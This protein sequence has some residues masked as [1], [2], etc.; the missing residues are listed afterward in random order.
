MRSWLTRV[1]T[2]SLLIS[3]MSVQAVP[4][5]WWSAGSPPVLSGSPAENKG[6]ASA[7]QGKWM[8]Q[9]ALTAL[10][11]KVGA[12]HPA[13]T[14]IT[15]ELYKASAT[16]EEG[17][18][19]PVRPATPDAAWLEAQKAPL[20]IGALKALA[21][22]FYRHIGKLNEEWIVDQFV[23]NGLLT[24]NVHYFRDNENLPKVYYPWNPANNQNPETNSASVTI[25]QLKAVFSLYFET[26]V[27]TDD[28]DGDGLG[29]ADEVLHGTNPELAD[30]DGDSLP[31][32]WEVEHGLDPLG[33]TNTYGDPDGEGV[34][35]VYEFVLGFDPN[36]ANTAGTS[37]ATKDRDGDGMTDAWEAFWGL[38]QWDEEAG[39]SVITKRI[40]W[41]VADSTA[42]YDGDGLT[43]FQEFTILS[44]PVTKDTD[45]DGMP[46]A[47]ELANNLQVNSSDWSSDPDN[48]DISNLDEYLLGL[49]PRNA[50]TGGTSDKTKDRDGDGILDR[51]EVSYVRVT[52]DENNDKI[53]E[54]TLDWEVADATADY[55]GDGLSNE[56]EFVEGTHPLLND[57]DYDNM[58][59]GWEIDNGFDPMQEA[60]QNIDTDNDGVKNIHEFVLGLDPR[61]ATTT[62]GV[63]DDT[64]DGDSDGMPDAWEAS[65]GR[66]VADP[67]TNHRNFQKTLDWTIDDSEEDFDEDE[68]E[69]LEEFLEGTNPTFFDSDGDQMP[70]GWEARH[71]LD[72]DSSVGSEGPNADPDNDGLDN[73]E[74]WCHGT[75]PHRAN[76]DG[77]GND[78]TNDG[79]EV[80]QGSDPNDS[81]DNGQAPPDLISVPI[82]IGDPSGSFS[83]KWCL[84]VRGLD[85]D[86]RTFSVASREF[87]DV[88]TE[89]ILLRKG[90][91]YEISIIHQG[92][93]PAW[94]A[95]P[96]AQP[97]YDWEATIDGKPEESAYPYQT[98]SG[99]LFTVADHWI[100]DNRLG[101]FTKYGDTGNENKIQGHHA[102]LIPGIRRDED[103]SDDN[104]QFL[105][106][107]LRKALPGQKMNLRVDVAHV[108]GLGQPTDCT[109]EISQGNPFKNYE[110]NQNRATLTKLTGEDLK[111]RSVH[112]HFAGSGALPVKAK[113]KILGNPMELEEVIQ[114]EKPVA[115]IDVRV[116]EIDFYTGDISGLRVGLYSTGDLVGGIELN[117]LSGYVDIS[118]DWPA[119]KWHWIQTGR[120]DVWGQ[121]SQGIRFKGSLNGVHGL[122]TVYPFFPS[123]PRI[124]T[125]QNEAGIPDLS[126]P[127]P[128]NTTGPWSRTA[129]AW[130]TPSH[131]I[132]GFVSTTRRDSFELY[133]MF[134]APGTE[135]KWVPLSRLDWSWQ[136]KAAT[137]LP[138]NTNWTIDRVYSTSNVAE[139]YA[140]NIHPEWNRRIHDIRYVPDFDVILPE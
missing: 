101:V 48:D 139:P 108:S 40:D 135:S 55:D 72:P 7:G 5:A 138:P 117:G 66:F 119:G 129:L 62:P 10:S 69:N 99:N 57:S 46:D 13:V 71:G 49:N 8:A 97:D 106:G 90:N 104:W 81:G 92:T 73:F 32:G 43:N 52:I 2:V 21:A 112:F 85:Q 93:S 17:V 126:G 60:N 15:A 63:P 44:S 86:S 124:Y 136:V 16:A 115:P 118:D 58:P 27:L 12:G 36:V 77:N 82:T 84:N 50:N 103:V 11:A 30:T 14:A 122:D 9:S 78:N 65:F 116:G 121:N 111:G 64:R 125:P 110:A 20:T 133:Q 89:N 67:D 80:E 6:M 113:F 29:Q 42:D 3:S 128:T 132:S 134:L 88:T 70:D 120:V 109:W 131:N 28:L 22:P 25:G 26:L 76:S 4:P 74:E 91:R 18:F 68:F 35:N 123:W 107:Q 19:Y 34:K 94:L 23:A 130:D 1:S 98:G 140:T 59:D 54:R 53:F 102:T 31:D 39:Y 87:G 79:E 95:T 37:D 75:D 83:E 137:S 100:V 41:D 38:L 33:T 127:T 61:D 114:V 45:E 51:V 56:D 47:W 96:G 105:T 24:E